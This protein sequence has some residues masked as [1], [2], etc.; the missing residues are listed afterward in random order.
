MDCENKVPY[1]VLRGY[2]TREIV[3]Q[4]G[5]TNPYGERAIC[6]KCASN[7]RKMAEIQRH[8]DNIKADNQAAKSAGWG[9]Y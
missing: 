7:P 1:Y 5:R 9:E 3:V 2:S 4:C 8:E 6:D